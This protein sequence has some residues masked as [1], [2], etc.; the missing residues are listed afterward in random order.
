MQSNPEIHHCHSIRLPEYDYSQAGAYFVTVCTQNRGCLF[1]EIVGGEMRENTLGQMVHQVWEELPRH[2]PGVD[3]DAFVVMPN[4]VHAIVVIQDIP[5]GAIHELPLRH[6]QPHQ[7]SP[8]KIN[9]LHRRRM[10]L[11]RIIGRFK[12]NS[13]KHINQLCNTRGVPVWQRNY[14]EHTV[15]NHKSLVEIRQY[16]TDNPLRWELDEENPINIRKVIPC[17]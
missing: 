4:H 13:A 6:E 14:Y 7:E 15:R 12:M 8:P 1:G 9:G 3:I 17:P 5:V 11:P 16:I 10:L 2:Y